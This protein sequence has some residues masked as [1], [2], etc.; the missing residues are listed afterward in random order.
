MVPAATSLAQAAAA[1]LLD[2]L[3]AHHEVVVEVLAGI[4]AVGAD[5]ADLRRQ[6]DDEVGA[7]VVV[8]P[9][10]AGHVDEIVVARARDDDLAGAARAQ[11]LDDEG[12][13]E[14]GAA[15]DD[16]ALALDR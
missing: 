7:R 14:A 5:A 8:E 6:V 3:H 1:P 11:L 15:G 16:D 10:H 2:E 12:A 9:A 4:L 13:E